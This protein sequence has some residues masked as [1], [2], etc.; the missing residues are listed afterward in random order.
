MIPWV[1]STIGIIGTIFNIY[2]HKSCFIFWAISNLGFIVY[3]VYVGFWSQ[4]ALFV[5]N[6]LAAIWGYFQWR[7]DER[8]AK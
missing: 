7:K 8:G 6:L 3:F 4:V 1:F 5:V 2:K